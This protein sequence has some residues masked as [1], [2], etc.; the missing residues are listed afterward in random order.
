MNTSLAEHWDKAYASNNID[1]LGWYEEESKPSLYLI[2]QLNLSPNATILNVGAGNSTITDDLLS[3]GFKNIIATDISKI[4]LDQL[5]SR[6]SDNASIKYVVDD[7]TQPSV[8]TQLSHIDLWYDRA[9]LHFL[10][11]EE[12]IKQYFSLLKDK[13]QIGGYVILA[14]FAKDIGAQKCSNLP[15]LRYDTSM[16]QKALGPTFKLIES[17]DHV[18]INPGGGERPYVYALFQRIED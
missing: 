6:I 17:F 8:L 10:I 13:V 3:R 7:L 16:M 4:A 2:D 14:T 11:D 5:K 12:D 1:R 9:V 18:Y 15:V